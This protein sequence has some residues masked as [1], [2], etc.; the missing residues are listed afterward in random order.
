MASIKNNTT[1]A[2]YTFPMG[3][4]ANIEKNIGITVIPIPYNDV[5]MLLNYGG[6]TINLSLSWKTS[7]AADVG[8]LYNNFSS[9]AG[10]SYTVD[11]SAEW[12][13]TFTG[14]V[15]RLSVK[16]EPGENVW[17]CE[18]VLDIGSVV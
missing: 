1:G 17:D 5:P 13:M 14:Y 18:L 9:A 7:N 3:L 2:V 4:A 12:G 6:A 15:S 10:V 16:Q 11:L 8:N